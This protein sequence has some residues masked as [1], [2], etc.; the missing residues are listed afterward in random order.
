MEHLSAL[1]FIVIREDYSFVRGVAKAAIVVY[2]ASSLI[3]YQRQAKKKGR[4]RQ[5]NVR[6]LSAQF[7]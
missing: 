2:R 6:K 1:R 5:I 7:E 4:R 3:I